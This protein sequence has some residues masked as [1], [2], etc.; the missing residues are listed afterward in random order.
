MIENVLSTG[1]FGLPMETHQGTS[2]FLFLSLHLN[3]K[4]SLSGFMAPTFK[5]NVSR[6]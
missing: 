1:L 2:F 3:A 5:G 4:S 6:E